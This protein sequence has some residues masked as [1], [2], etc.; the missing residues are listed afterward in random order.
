MSLVSPLIVGTLPVVLGI[1]AEIV[2]SEGSCAHPLFALCGMSDFVDPCDVVQYLESS[3]STFM[4]HVLYFTSFC[5][6]VDSLIVNTL[7]LFFYL[8]YCHL[9]YC[10]VFVSILQFMPFH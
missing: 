4:L 10:L 3:K 6:S 7:N 8:L 5:P 1:S 2:M 9:L